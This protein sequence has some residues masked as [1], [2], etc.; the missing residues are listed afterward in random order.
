MGKVYAHLRETKTLG[1]EGPSSHL[2]TEERQA[3]LYITMQRSVKC[4]QHR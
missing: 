4:A 1:E 2:E 3:L